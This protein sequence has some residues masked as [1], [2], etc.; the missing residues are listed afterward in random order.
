MAESAESLALDWFA[1]TSRRVDD[2]DAEQRQALESKHRFRRELAAAQ[3]TS[4]GDG[5]DGE[6]DSGNSGLRTPSGVP[7]SIIEAKSIPS[8]DELLSVLRA[9]QEAQTAQASPLSDSAQVIRVTYAAYALALNNLFEEAGRLQES[10]WYWSGVED[11]SSATALYLLQTLPARLNLLAQEAYRVLKNGARS[12]AD[13]SSAPP[14]PINRETIVAT[15]RQLRK[16][17]DVVV[18]AL[19]PHAIKQREDDEREASDEVVTASSLGKGNGQKLGGKALA[20]PLVLLRKAK[21]LSPLT[22]TLHEANTKQKLLRKRRNQVAKKLGALASTAL[23]LSKSQEEVTAQSADE[24]VQLL[25]S[26]LQDVLLTDTATP[27]P[28]FEASSS[29]QVYEALAHV[30]ENAPALEYPI[31]TVAAPIGLSPPSRLAMLW[32]RL[33]LWPTLMFFG[34]RLASRNRQAIAEAIADGKETIKG[35]FYNWV[36]DPVMD[37]LNTI[38]GGDVADDGGIVTKEGRKADLESLERMVTTYAVDK[39][40]ISAQDAARAEE[41][42][43]KVREGDLDVVMRAYEDQLK[44]PFKALTMGSLPRLL[45]IQVQKAKY[46]LAVA[47]S[48]I[49]HLLKSQALLFGAVGIAPAM[50]ILWL[51][52]RGAKWIVRGREMRDDGR[53]KERAWAAMRRVDRLL[54][55]GTSS[56][57]HAGEGMSDKAYGL[58]LLELADL[59]RVAHEILPHGGGGKKQ[60][61]LRHRQNKGKSQTKGRARSDSRLTDFLDDVRDLETIAVTA[62]GSSSS[63]TD[64]MAVQ[65]RAVERMWRCWGSVLTLPV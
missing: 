43:R 57:T 3:S 37:L 10:S 62:Q 6:G 46:D 53:E 63:G 45:L 42:R 52:F 7:A 13:S 15:I 32:P 44:S 4:H 27:Q 48:G 30:L 25:V 41:L 35:F 24:E 14:P 2:L 58:L 21:G 56:P 65:T 16:T 40:Q 11:S 19:W 59:R 55:R 61:R 49:D 38:K 17:P 31:V 54:T 20:G 47:M 60:S 26:K 29:V 34:L 50:G 28:R 33:V 9:L 8:R 18:G 51:G 39:G 12:A 22:L 36:V 5:S 1:S 23:A 64:G